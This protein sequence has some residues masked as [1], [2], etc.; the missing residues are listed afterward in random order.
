MAVRFKK[1]RTFIKSHIEGGFRGASEF[2]LK[3]YNT[4]VIGFENSL[5]KILQP[6]HQKALIL[7]TGGAAKGVSYVLKKLNINYLVVSRTPKTGQISYSDINADLLSEYTLIINTTP[8]GTF[9]N[10]DAC[11][12][13]PYKY[14]TNKHLLYDLIYN[15]EKTLFLKNGEMQGAAIKNGLEMLHGQALAAWDI[16]NT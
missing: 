12:D 8:T 1:V 16:W 3:G 5:K 10:T 15:P 4:D 9:P 2:Y 6:Q 13:I 11:P 14:L 7:G